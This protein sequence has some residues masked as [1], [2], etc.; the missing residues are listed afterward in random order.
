MLR[1]IDARGKLVFTKEVKLKSAEEQVELNVSSLKKGH[2]QIELIADNKT[3]GSIG[4]VV[5][6]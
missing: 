1:V 5:A 4:F 2:Y 6:R 3:I